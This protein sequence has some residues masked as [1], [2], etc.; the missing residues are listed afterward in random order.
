MLRFYS[1]SYAISRLIS[2]TITVQ[3]LQVALMKRG[4]LFTI[5]TLALFML[6]WTA[7]PT[8]GPSPVM[9]QDISLGNYAILHDS[10]IPASDSSLNVTQLWEEVNSSVSSLNIENYTRTISENYPSRTWSVYNLTPS[11]HLENAWHWANQTLQEVTSGA[12]TFRQITDHQSLIATQYGAD[13]EPKAAVIIT[14]VI[15][16][17]E[18]PSANDAGASVAVVLEMANVLSNYSL[19]FDIHY[20]L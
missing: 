19:G 15:D 8:K 4:R 7:G 14:G 11:T 2:E 10:A 16:G 13:P 1:E 5:F 6:L 9:P 3:L 12:L 20:V 17:D 18:T